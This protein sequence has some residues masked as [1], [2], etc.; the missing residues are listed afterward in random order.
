[1]IRGLPIPDWLVM[2][3]Q[4]SYIDWLENKLL[5]RRELY[6][7]SQKL[8]IDRNNQ[9][10]HVKRKL[11]KTPILPKGWSNFKI[12]ETQ[13]DGCFTG[14]ISI[15]DHHKD[16]R[17]WDTKGRLLLKQYTKDYIEMKT[18]LR[19]ER[20]LH[21]HGKCGSCQSLYECDCKVDKI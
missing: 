2:Q 14:Q 8:L 17:D 6:D 20:K 21:E 10:K 16:W 1:M 11:S 5:R 3:N 12:I 18:G 4:A 13:I 7:E 15:E 19:V 9:L